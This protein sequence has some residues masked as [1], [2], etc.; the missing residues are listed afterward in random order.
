MGWYGARGRL[1][2]MWSLVIALVIQPATAWSQ[3]Q[4]PFPPPFPPEM[5]AALHQI[6][7]QRL[8]EAGS[9]GAVVGVWIPGRGTWVHAQGT[10]DLATGAPIRVAD[11]F[12]IG[13]ITKTFAATVLL[14]LVDE[15]RLQLD[16][17][18]EQYVPGVP[19][20]DRITIRQVLGMTAGIFSYTSD[21][22]FEAEYDADPLMPFS[23]QDLLAILRRHPPDFAPGEG[24]HYSDTN[25]YL[26]GLI[27]EQ[28]TGQRVG[29]A[30]EQRI[31]QPLRLTS[32]SYPTT[33]DMPEPYAHGYN[34]ESSG[35]LRDVTRSNPGVAGAAGAMLSTLDDL[36]LW[37]EALAQ[38]ALLSPTMQRERLQWSAFP[39]GEAVNS[40]YGLGIAAFVSFIGHSGG[41]AGYESMAFHLPEANA[42]LVVLAN[43]SGLFGG[44]AAQ[45]MFLE[46]ANLL[47]PGRF[48]PLAATAR[49]ERP[50]RPALLAARGISADSSTSLVARSTSS[51]RA[52]VASPPS[53][54]SAPHVNGYR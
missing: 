10:G 11:R 43:K 8:T 37:T 17:R 47:F 23:L 31:L 21:A 45:P 44:G 39:G 9:P 19:N 18:L 54:F 13:S 46:I 25:Y 14:Q 4:P 49:A 42:T 51:A 52:R 7:E 48:P 16:D 24:V 33:P 41:I 15:G 36:R 1:L 28:V 6:V 26:L 53:L 40:R 22:T 50:A 12:R 34:A 35:A 20:G 2:V 32:T 38:G 30:I 29:Q 5:Q 3:A 27:I